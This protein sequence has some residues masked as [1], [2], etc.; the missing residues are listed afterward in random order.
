VPKIDEPP[1]AASTRTAI[2]WACSFARSFAL[3]KTLAWVS[4]EMTEGRHRHAIVLRDPAL[5][6]IISIG[7]LVKCRLAEC[8]LEVAVL[9]DH[10][11]THVIPQ[12]FVS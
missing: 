1:L 4:S 2:V 5:Q 9:R 3:W 10:A 11:R 7:D 6:G 8:R 12:G